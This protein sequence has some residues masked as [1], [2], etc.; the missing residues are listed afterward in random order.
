MYLHLTYIEKTKHNEYASWHTKSHATTNGA[1]ADIPPAIIPN[2]STAFLILPVTAP[3]VEPVSNNIKAT[4]AIALL[5]KLLG[6]KSPVTLS[7]MA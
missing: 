3:N 4:T 5:L 1:T 7:N 2:H 6:N